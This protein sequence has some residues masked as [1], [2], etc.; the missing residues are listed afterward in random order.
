VISY[1]VYGLEN[2]KKDANY[3]FASN[4]ESALDILLVFA[5]LPY[6]IV[7]ISKI[8]LKR[9]PLF[10]LAMIAGG[11]FFVDRSNHKKS[12]ESLNKAKDSMKKNP[13]SIILY[14]EGTRSID[15]SIQPFKKGGLVMAMNL[16]VPVVPIAM[17]GTREAM[18]K[19][20]LSLRKNPLELR[21]GK[22]IETFNIEFENRNELAN[23][24]RNAII[25][26]KSEWY[27][28]NNKKDPNDVVKN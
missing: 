3:V 23:E 24:V 15:G 18:N 26:L 12:M 8:E 25:E 5:G 17:C 11:H 22:P 1:S 13:R 19:N 16:D 2:L 28:N 4:H 14:P 6:H 21:I 9:V 20:A 27:K 10:G 7:F